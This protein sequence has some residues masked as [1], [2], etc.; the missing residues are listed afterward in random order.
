MG[1][2]AA[3]TGALLARRPLGRPL[4]AA[5]LGP[6]AW[7][8]CCCPPRR[9]HG[10]VAERFAHLGGEDALALAQAVA[11]WRPD[12]CV[13]LGPAAL[14]DGL[15]EELPGARLG[16]ILADASEEPEGWSATGLHR[17]ASFRP[18][19]TGETAGGMR[20][21]RAFPPP[22]ADELFA[23]VRALHHPP[24]AMTIGRATRHREE[25]LTPAKHHHDL[26]QA[27]HGLEGEELRALLGEHDVGVYVPPWPGPGFGQQAGVHLAAGQLL[28]SQPLSPLHG[29]ERGIDYV[30]FHSA[31]ELVWIL[32][33]I[34]RF[35]EMHQSV[36]V[37]GRMKAEWFRASRLF[38]RILE[39]L[40]ADIA[41]FG[42]DGA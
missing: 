26:L 16:V 23:P 32:D 28:L 37:R 20:L 10:L 24:R 19:L 12:V 13:A 41:A 31:D 11:G 38:A 1:L 42:A 40:L 15:L 39:D 14:P 18:V 36:R 4:R 17:L 3:G 27:V 21:W 6:P 35:P 30:Q 29:L 34:G 9:A 22:V 7:L 2:E 5:F 8:S 25:L 33:R